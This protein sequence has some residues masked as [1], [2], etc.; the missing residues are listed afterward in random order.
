MRKTENIRLFLLGIWLVVQLCALSGCGRGEEITFFSE[1]GFLKQTAEGAMLQDFV[2]KETVSGQELFVEDPLEAETYVDTSK[3]MV[4]ICGA[5]KEPGVVELTE[6]SR[7]NDA[8]QAAGGFTEEASV[9]S[10][11]LAAK[12][13]DEEMIFV[14]TKEEAESQ[15]AA[16]V[17]LPAAENNLININ[18]ADIYMLCSLP[19]I[20][21][22]KARDIV[23][24]REVHGSFQKKEDIMQVTGIKE[25]LYKKISN[26]IS[27]K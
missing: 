4:Y 26:L 7:M 11:N 2:V 8:V 23:T 25:S 22:S 12:L 13:K 10:I 24:Y 3:I 16:G 6:G 17:G 14:P 18:T 9:T 5:V 27:V 19:G 15:E 20:G 1:E 21:E